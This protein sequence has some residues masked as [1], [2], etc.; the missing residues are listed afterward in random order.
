MFDEKYKSLFQ[1]I[2][3]NEKHKEKLREIM[4]KEQT[5]MDKHIGNKRKYDAKAVR[6]TAAAA[7]LF[8]TSFALFKILG[9]GGGN[10]PIAE[11]PAPPAVVETPEE[12]NE[13]LYS[14][15]NFAEPVKVDAPVAL[16]G[17]ADK[18]AA[19][20]ENI[21][22]EGN[23]VFKG[24]VTDVRFKEYSYT[25]GS[26]ESEGSETQ[27]VRQSVIYEM[28]VDRIF[29]SDG[30]FSEGETIIIENDLYTYTSLASSVE[31]LKINRQYIL[32][33]Y[34]NDGEVYIPADTEELESTE[35]LESSLSVLYPFTT[36][37]EITE[38]GKYIF[39]DHWVSLIN[40]ETKTVTMDIEEGFGYYGEMKLREDEN[41]ESDFQ[42]LVDTYL[43][44]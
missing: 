3:G 14:S 1:N 33:L 5:E 9:D 26:E 7:L 20:T 24:T 32:A 16:N 37:I 40:E 39:P 27:A 18:I 36:Q 31:K 29:Y 44:K 23:A 2:N 4:Q 15:L 11:N 13:V 30:S 21:L 28:K 35:K 41:F 10:N 17:M 25:V 12:E 19:F 22:S 8:I 6:Y 38:D 42:S 34:E 43:G